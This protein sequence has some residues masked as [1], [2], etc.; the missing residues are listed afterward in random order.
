MESIRGLSGSSVTW[1]AQG[2]RFAHDGKLARASGKPAAA[3]LVWTDVLGA[4]TVGRMPVQVVVDVVGHQA[5]GPAS[6][7]YAVGIQNRTE[8]DRLVDAIHSRATGVE[9][10]PAPAADP[11]VTERAPATA[12][13]FQV[14]PGGGPPS[15]EMQRVMRR[16]LLLMNLGV[17]L[18]AIPVALMVIGIL[19][20]VVVVLVLI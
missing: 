19:A 16:G 18:A 4:H 9:R 15:P 8:A 20:V 2:I 7:P 12:R 5:K 3:A 6:D 10:G 13:P 11:V 1:D 17:W 14:N